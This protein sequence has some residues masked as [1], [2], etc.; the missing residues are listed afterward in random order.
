M[1]NGD[2]GIRAGVAEVKVPHAPRPADVIAAIRKKYAVPFV[3][4]LTV[5]DVPE[6][7]SVNVVQFVPSTEY[8][9][10]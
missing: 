6:A 3:K 1:F 7:S 8:S 4:P 9:M 5:Y 10:R 2:N